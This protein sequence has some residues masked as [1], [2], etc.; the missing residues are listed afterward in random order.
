MDLQDELSCPVCMKSFKTKKGCTTH[1]TTARSC[2]WYR[3]GKLAQ[4]SPLDL[5]GE[6]GEALISDLCDGDGQSD[7]MEDQRSHMDEYVVAAM[8]DMADDDDLFDFIP[9]PSAT[10]ATLPE[11]QI[12]EAGPGPSTAR[13]LLHRV[14]DD[15]DDSRVEDPFQAAGCV[16]RMNENLHERW[17]NLF[18]S[19]LDGEGDITMG[20]DTPAPNTFYPFASELDW[21]VADWVIK[22]GPGNNAFD[23]FLSI[24]GVRFLDSLSTLMF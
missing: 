1:L 10:L 7:Q 12:G 14:L 23:R 21:R 5:D 2:C 4:L 19:G 9:M 20:A 18:G 6:G 15:E 17:R 22:D 16:I 11:V 24:P 3:R 8:D 13:H